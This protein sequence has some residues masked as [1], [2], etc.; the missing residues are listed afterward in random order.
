MHY[1]AS[2][3]RKENNQPT[4]QLTTSKDYYN[5]CAI[6]LT[7]LLEHCQ[8]NYSRGKEERHAS[9]SVE[10][11]NLR[12]DLSSSNETKNLSKISMK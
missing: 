12:R 4:N 11:A 7:A 5:S 2:V 6:Y 10:A 9:A 1:V 8:L 3:K